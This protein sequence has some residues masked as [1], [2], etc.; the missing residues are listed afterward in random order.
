MLKDIYYVEICTRIDNL[1]LQNKPISF[2]L[3]Y[4]HKT[5]SV[6]LVLTWSQLASGFLHTFFNIML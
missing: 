2:M 4:L 1:I 5:N 3:S 6:C